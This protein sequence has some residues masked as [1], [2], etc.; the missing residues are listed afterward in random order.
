M[1]TTLI[2]K[3]PADGLTGKTD[4]DVLGF[5]YKELD[6]YLFKGLYPDAKTLALIKEKHKMAQHKR[7]INLPFPYAKYHELKG[8][9]SF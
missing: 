3:A 6:D 5:T 1:P 9:Y 2:D 7:V 4:E 8:E